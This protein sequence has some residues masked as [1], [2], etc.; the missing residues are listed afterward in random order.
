MQAV[1]AVKLLVGE[2]V[3]ASHSGG[4]A[5]RRGDAEV[6]DVEALYSGDAVG[7][8]VGVEVE[9]AEVSPSG[10][11][12]EHLEDAE[13]EGSAV[14]FPED[15]G[16]GRAAALQLEASAVEILV[17]VEATRV[18][19]LVFGFSDCSPDLDSAFSLPDSYSLRR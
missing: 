9:D 11:A 18:F 15:V 2:E 4:V 19:E 10:D 12:V 14:G 7:P 13:A 5:E 8:L 1:F 16:V 3:E 17:V 6:E